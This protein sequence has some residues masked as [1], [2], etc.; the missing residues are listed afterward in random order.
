AFIALVLVFF[1]FYQRIYPH[2]LT[3]CLAHKAFF[4]SIPTMLILAGLVI[5]LGFE[6]MF[7]WLASGVEKLGFPLR[8]TSVY[9]RLNHHFRGIGKEFMPALD[10]GAFLLMPTLMPHAGTAETKETLQLLDMAVTAIPEVERVV[11]K[12]GRVESALDP[13]PLSMFE[14]IVL[15][16]SEYITDKDGNKR[17]FKV[18]EEGRFLVRRPLG[19]KTELIAIEEKDQPY[20]DAAWLI[21]DENGRYFRQWR[22]E[23]KSP[24]DIWNEIAKATQ[25]PWITSSPKLQPIETRLVMLQTGMRATLGIKIK[26]TDLASIEQFGLELE[27][28]LKKVP[29][30]NAEA[31]FAERIVGKPYLEIEWNRTRMARYGIS[32]QDAQMLLETVVGGTPLTTT[33]EGRERYAVSVRYPRTWRQDP[34]N[35]KRILIPTMMNTNVPLG[36]I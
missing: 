11:G 17:R 1:E 29:A 22:K 6:T 14:N 5:W 36:E 26:G 33:V 10:E 24:Q 3:W 28:H 31:V 21:P 19:N 8:Q 7:G 25:F 18:D 27:K 16:K 13:A 30:L 23:I 12:A 15:Y 34:E 20:I 32:M 4:L 9:S 35:L 2:V